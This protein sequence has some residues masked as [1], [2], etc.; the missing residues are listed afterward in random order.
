[1]PPKELPHKATM[2]AG[3]GS[4]FPHQPPLGNNKAPGE[5]L[6]KDESNAGV[7]SPEPPAA[8][9]SP[10][11]DRIP[12]D[13]ETTAPSAPPARINPE[14]PREDGASSSGQAAPGRRGRK[15][16]GQKTSEEDDRVSSNP[17][18]DRH[19][20][21]VGERIDSDLAALAWLDGTSRS[22]IVREVCDAYL[23]RR[24]GEVKLA[25]EQQ[26]LLAQLRQKAKVIR[27]G[28]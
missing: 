9:S 15:P 7:K 11:V 8:A 26:E 20:Y 24:S 23:H 6:K 17:D 19:T 22:A 16:R 27:I 21:V 4:L 1:M 10:V 13:P 28:A 3:M 18:T 2:P 5:V 14:L 25:R 12:G